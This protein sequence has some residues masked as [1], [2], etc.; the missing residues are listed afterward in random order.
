MPGRLLVRRHAPCRHGWI[1]CRRPLA[2]DS[3]MQFDA[4]EF[5]ATD[6]IRIF[7]F[8]VDFIK[9]SKSADWPKS[10]ISHRS[11]MRNA[12]ARIIEKGNGFGSFV[13]GGGAG[14]ARRSPVIV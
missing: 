5:G 9:P 12:P 8:H 2:L 1:W 3:I 10:S 13:S 7:D 4:D 14:G 11:S 6:S